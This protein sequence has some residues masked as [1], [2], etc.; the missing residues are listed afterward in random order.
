MAAQLSDKGHPALQTVAADRFEM[1]LKECRSEAR[2]S[3]GLL[4]L[5]ANGKK[6]LQKH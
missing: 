4:K 1:L 3:E 5:V 2:P 6:S